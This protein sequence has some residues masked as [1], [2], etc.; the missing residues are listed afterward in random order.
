M[1]ARQSK[2][3]CGE[4]SGNNEG[5]IRID[6]NQEIERTGY[7]RINFKMSKGYTPAGI[8]IK[9]LGGST[10]DS[11]NY[12]THSCSPRGDYQTCYYKFKDFSLSSADTRQ[13]KATITTEKD[14]DSSKKIS[15]QA[16]V[17]VESAGSVGGGER[18][19]SGI[20]C[21]G[22]CCPVGTH[23]S[24]GH[25]CPKGKNWNGKKCSSLA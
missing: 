12:L 5:W 24:S 19:S 9:P 16:R 4:S 25:C 3:Y 6:T 21:N 14:E 17:T 15:A 11:L 8:T 23:C 13:R 22:Q 20:I 7:A 2:Y 18:C 1:G 10:P